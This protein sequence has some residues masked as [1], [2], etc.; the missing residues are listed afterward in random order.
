MPN[1][2][3]PEIFRLN[4]A[5]EG[6]LEYSYL[7]EKRRRDRNYEDAEFMNEIMRQ[8]KKDAGNIG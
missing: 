8:A 6:Q 1:E 4:E 5:E 3:E 7:L 2:S